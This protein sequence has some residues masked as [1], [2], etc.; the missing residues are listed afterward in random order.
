[1]KTLRWCMLT[2]ATVLFSR[3]G[4]A[5]AA[6]GNSGTHTLTQ[7]SVTPNLAVL[8]NGVGYFAPWGWSPCGTVAPSTDLVKTWTSLSQ[9]ALLSG[10]TVVVYW[11]DCSGSGTKYITGIT[12]NQ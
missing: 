8:V 10:K 4:T 11:D 6:T 3:L 5:H 1:M 9:A 2:L 12:L 7:A